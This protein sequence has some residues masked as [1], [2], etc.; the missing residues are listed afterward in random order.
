[1]TL[2]V[3]V[4]TNDGMVLAADDL[5]TDAISFETTLRT[6]AECP[7]CHTTHEVTKNVPTYPTVSNFQTHKAK[8]M[9]FVEKFGIG[10][11]GM[12]FINGKSISWHMRLIEEEVRKQLA[13]ESYTTH[14][15]GRLA[16]EEL[17]KHIAQDSK[18][19]GDIPFVRLT[20]IGYDRMEPRCITIA[21]GRNRCKEEIRDGESVTISGDTRVMHSILSEVERNGYAP[22][23]DHFSLYDAKG[24][25]RF[26]L[27]TASGFHQ[28]STLPSTIGSGIMLGTIIP[29]ENFN[30]VEVEERRQ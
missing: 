26:L 30:I 5:I 9:S 13:P 19:I 10:Y 8:I 1:V 14:N 22:P 15:I 6:T 24:Y 4:C 7:K 16:A 11:S 29:N 20:I 27:R 12:S 21:I 28:Y 2:I 17:S 3:S 25:A 23:T 18:L